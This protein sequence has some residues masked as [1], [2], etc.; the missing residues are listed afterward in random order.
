M[1]TGEG[2]GGI[3]RQAGREEIRKGRVGS[4]GKMRKEDREKG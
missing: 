2:R 3:V 4:E 1:K